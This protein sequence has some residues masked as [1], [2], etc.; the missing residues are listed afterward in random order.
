MYSILQ[1]KC[2]LLE[3]ETQLKAHG[4]KRLAAQRFYLRWQSLTVKS[5]ARLPPV[6]QKKSL[7]T[8]GSDEVQSLVDVGDLVEA[9]LAAVGLGQGLAGDHL[10]QQHE[11]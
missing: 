3:V 6:T 5:S 10:Q 8:F 7:I 4:V 9:H 1:D 11:L 2:F